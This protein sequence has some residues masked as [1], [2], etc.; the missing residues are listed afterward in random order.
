[1]KNLIRKPRS[2]FQIIVVAAILLTNVFA[3]A[4][5]KP[6]VIINQP[7][8]YPVLLGDIEI[9]ALSD[10][11]LPLNL[12]DILQDGKP[13]EI[14]N[15]L[16]ENYQTTALQCSVNAY[17][18][19]TGGKLILIDAGTSDIYGPAL[20]HLTENL[21]KAGYQP[22]QINAVLLTHI[23]MDHIGGIASGDKLTFPNA[24][25]YISRIEA[26]YYLNPENKAKAP[27]AAKRFFDGAVLKLAPVVKA[28]KLKKFEFGA[29]LFPGITPVESFGHTPGHAFY[30]VESQNQK[31]LFWG[32][33][34]ASDIVQFADP[35]ITSAF[36][37][38]AKQAA[39]TRS[40]ALM[41]AVKGGYWVAVAHSSFPGIGHISKKGT[42][43]R[44]V[45]INF[46]TTGVGQ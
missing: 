40:K 12:N 41:N 24:N 46:S 45:P 17:L 23:H 7:G 32:D 25:I 36:D 18:I 5:L 38:D 16:K 1:M 20:G 19:K 43:F 2:P 21:L 8:Y 3:S 9:V 37:Y 11:T 13:G 4:Q 30:K 39:V 22:E 34:I 27:A 31:M 35:F 6:P 42:G 33:I 26:E 29:E 44:L 15:L 14:N 10:G 28:G